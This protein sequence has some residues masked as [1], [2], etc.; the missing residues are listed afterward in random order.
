M[1]IVRFTETKLKGKISKAI[2][3]FIASKGY[4]TNFTLDALEMTQMGDG[5]YKVHLSCDAQ[6]TPND[7]DKIFDIIF[8]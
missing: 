5:S 6:L 2:S 7:I 8:K 1:D 4:E 3:K